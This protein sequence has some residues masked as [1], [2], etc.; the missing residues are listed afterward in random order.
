MR[1]FITKIEYDS[2]LTQLEIE[3]IYGIEAFNKCRGCGPGH[4]PCYCFHVKVD[5]NKV[6]NR[7]DKIECEL[8]SP[9]APTIISSVHMS[10]F[11]SE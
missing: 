4:G 6:E 3:Q 5:G 11:Y 9:P 1:R 2:P 8:M 10:R 7:L